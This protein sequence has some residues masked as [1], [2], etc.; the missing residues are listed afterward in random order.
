MSNA[1]IHIEEQLIKVN[2]LL[3]EWLA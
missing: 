1:S 3:G 2:A